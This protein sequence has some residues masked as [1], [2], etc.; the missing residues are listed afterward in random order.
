M[1]KK[2][3]VSIDISTKTVVK[4]VFVLL[5]LLLLYLLRDIIVILFATFVLAAALMPSVDWL[6][7][8]KIPRALSVILIYLAL[9]GVVVGSVYLLIPPI[10][11]QVRAL[12]TQFPELYDRVVPRFFG[13]EGSSLRNELVNNTQNFFATIGDNLGVAARGIWD[14]AGLIFGGILSVVLILVLSFYLIV[15]EDAWEKFV[16]AVVPRKR[17]PYIIDLIH[18]INSKIGRWLSGQIILC[19]IVGVLMFVGLWLLGLK[20]YALVL[21]IFAGIMEIIPYFGPIIGAIPAVFLAFVQS[22]LLALFVIILYFLIQQL[23]NHILVPKVMQKAIGI[24]PVVV[25]IALM[26]G[27]KLAGVLGMI[28]A[29]PVTT[30]LSVF[31]HDFMDKDTRSKMRDG[32][33]SAKTKQ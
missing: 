18:R 16:Q 27:G 22:P 19:V 24:N 8:R 4:I 2:Q 29:V 9:V 20:E 13:F 21:A 17:S 10:V 14:A 15:Q 26:V 3:Y 7:Q 23:E 5:F 30:A 33:S 25:I 12:E 1:R 28:L 31:L 32:Q 6:K 11:S